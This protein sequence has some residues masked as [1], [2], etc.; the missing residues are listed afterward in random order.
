M[1]H[2]RRHRSRG[3]SMVELALVAPILMLML[4]TILQF[5][6]IFAAQVGVINATREAARNAATTTPT[7]DTAAASTNGDFVYQRLLDTWFPRNVM[8]YD[9]AAVATTG[10]NR[11]QVCYSR[12]IDPSGRTA[13]EV[14]V[15]TTYRHRLFV[16][17]LAN[18]VDAFDGSADGRIG[19]TTSETMR[20]AN[21]EQLP[22][23]A[24]NIPTAPGVCYQ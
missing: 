13:I 15:T 2:D 6:Y 19:I 3:Q 11:T 8:A 23:Y 4:G 7:L 10:A 5:G 17:L 14:T 16:P 1:M 20:V 9:A 21:P 12:Y 22:A 18:V 24:G